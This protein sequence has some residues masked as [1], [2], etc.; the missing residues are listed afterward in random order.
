MSTTVF[1]EQCG[2][3]IS[4]AVK[5]CAYCG[6]AQGDEHEAET[7][8]PLDKPSLEAEGEASATIT[9]AS[10]GEPVPHVD[11]RPTMVDGNASIGHLDM[12]GWPVIAGLPIELWLVIAA[13]AVP[14]AWLTIKIA[15]LLPDAFK[16]LGTSYLGF[17]IGLALALVLAIVGLVGVAMLVISVAFSSGNTTA[18][19]W[20]MILSVLG[21]AILA[22]AP[23]IRSMFSTPESG[24]PPTS[25]IVSRTL[26]AT[27][28]AAA[29][30][31]AL[32]YFLLATFSAKYVVAGIIAA[33]IAIGASLVARR[34]DN[35]DRQARLTVT[36]GAGAS[37]LLL[38]ILG[39]AQN[40]LLVPIGLALAAV[41]FLWLP[42]DARAFFGDKPLEFPTA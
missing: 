28:S 29:I 35:G 36:I 5:F 38:L 25:V 23:R 19:T 9:D 4:P 34:L 3:T 15:T 42:N 32:I 20:A 7:T 13:F 17:R 22:V 10:S 1:C 37:V 39:R 24:G 11:A 16:L 14:G 21:S 41:G 33:A 2:E 26:I 30:V 12:S 31:V 40:G 8:A 27:F 6:A 18:A